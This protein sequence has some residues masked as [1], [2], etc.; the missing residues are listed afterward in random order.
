MPVSVF[1]DTNVLVYAY[2]VDAG[3]K[4]AAA[5]AVVE[6]GFMEPG[7]TAISIQVLRSFT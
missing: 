3:E 7:S 4:R 5:L 2:D 6:R 1:V